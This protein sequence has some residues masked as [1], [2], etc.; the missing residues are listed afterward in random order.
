MQHFKSL[1]YVYPS[2]TALGQCVKNDASKQPSLG[3]GG[4][5]NDFIAAR[6]YN[7]CVEIFWT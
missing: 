1:H 2:L 3:K 5:S 6:H 7:A 4:M